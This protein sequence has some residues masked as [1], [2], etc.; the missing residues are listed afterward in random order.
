MEQKQHAWYDALLAPHL[1]EVGNARP[2]R[3]YEEALLR[4]LSR[5][6]SAAL[7]RAVTRAISELTVQVEAKLAPSAAAPA[8]S[9]VD[10]ALVGEQW[11]EGHEGDPSGGGGYAPAKC[12]PS[13]INVELANRC[14][15]FLECCCEGHYSD[16][17]EFIRVQTSMR[18][19]VNLVIDMV[20]SLLVLERSLCSLTIS[21]TCQ[22]YQ[23][24]IELVQGPCPGNQRFLIGTNLCDVAVRFMHS[25]YPDC[26]VADVIEL[27]MLCL[28]LLLAMVEGVP[29]D[30]IPRRIAS[31]LDGNKIVAE[32]DLCYSHSGCVG[33]KRAAERGADFRP[34]ELQTSYRDLGFHF[35][36]LVRTLAKHAPAM[37]D[38][39]RRRAR[40]Y[41]Y[42]AANTGAIEIVRSDKTIEEV[43]FTV[44]NLCMWLSDKSKQKLEWEVDRSTPQKRIEDFVKRSEGMIHE[45]RHNERISHIPLFYFL[46]RMSGSV[47][48]LMFVLSWLTNFCILFCTYPDTICVED[49]TLYVTRDCEQGYWRVQFDPP[50]VGV[51]VTLLGLGLVFTCCA[52]LLEHC[53]VTLPLTLRAAWEQRGVR[54]DFPEIWPLKVELECIDKEPQHDSQA[55]ADADDSGGADGASGDVRLSDGPTVGGAARSGGGENEHPPSPSAKPLGEGGLLVLAEEEAE[56]ELLPLREA[57]AKRAALLRHVVLVS[58][59]IL[60]Q[61]DRVLAY[62]LLYLLICAL[63]LLYSPFF[64]VI[65]LFDIVVR[66]RLLQKVI[67]AVTVNSESL[68]LTFV[69]VA[70]VVYHFTLLGQLYF[71]TD[72]IWTFHDANGVQHSVDLCGSTKDCLMTTFYLGLSYEGLAQGIADMREQWFDNPEKAHIRWAVDLLFYIAVIVMLLNIIFGIVI[73]T[74]AQ[75]RDLQNQ[76]KD[77]MENVCFICSIDRNTFDRRHPF[78]FDFHTERE[79]NVWHYLSFMIHLRMK[80]PTEYTGPESYVA[81]MLARGDLSFFPILKTGHLRPGERT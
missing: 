7:S 15:V 47:H 58:P 65:T 37:L 46:S 35:F 56:G 68:S 51:I 32:L 4:K 81:E 18:T 50:F 70:V 64:F 29:G 54:I 11:A 14:L 77:N 8:P 38:L 30:V 62:F 55:D 42:Y 71:R 76:I 48:Y 59:P 17:Q 66:S 67:E 10:P 23:T 39:C 72:F 33:E 1:H 41:D 34:S 80:R 73:D 61:Q 2:L 12:L 45:M 25:S 74:F 28:K 63:G 75:Q 19:Q 22:L 3:T 5:G 78:G 13:S 60:L 20:N 52:S 6:S 53:V 36:L 9:T 27:K 26:D 44:P 43:Y 16:M 69:L 21:L 31:S 49:D 40:S 57:R 79:H 24:L